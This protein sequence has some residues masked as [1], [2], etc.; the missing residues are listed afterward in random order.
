[1]EQQTKKG[2][3]LLHWVSAVRGLLRTAGPV[4]HQE[5]RKSHSFY[6]ERGSVPFFPLCQWE[7]W[8]LR[9]TSRW[10]FPANSDFIITN[11]GQTK[12]IPLI[13]KYFQLSGKLLICQL[14]LLQQ[15]PV[16]RWVENYCCKN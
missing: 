1:M 5:L 9:T 8:R 12:F 3:S 11:N 7:F 15:A 4:L 14:V 10:S 2:V 13:K 16:L 6:R